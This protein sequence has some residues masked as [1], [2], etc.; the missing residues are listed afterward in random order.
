VRGQI[1]VSRWR[2]WL[3]GFSGVAVTLSVPL[4]V[5]APYNACAQETTYTLTIRNHRFEPAEIEIP[6]GQKISLVLKNLD[7]SPERFDSIRLRRE[8][9]IAGGQEVTIYVGPLRPGR[10]Q[11]IGHFNP[12]TARGHIIVK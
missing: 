11:F 1:I 3:C 4:L 6:A 12:T 7:P 2:A 9:A 8:Q 10:Y 5:T